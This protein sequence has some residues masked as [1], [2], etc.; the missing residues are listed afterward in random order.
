MAKQEE[1]TSTS[2]T[3]WSSTDKAS[4]IQLSNGNLT[5]AG[6]YG[7]VRAT[8]PIG[9]EGYYFEMIS[10]KEGSSFIIIGLTPA[11]SDLTG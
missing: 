6:G 10:V 5:A 1:P 8:H 2:M 3:T 11:G 9:Q 4:D 7:C